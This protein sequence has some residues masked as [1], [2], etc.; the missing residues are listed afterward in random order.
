VTDAENQM[1]EINEL[2]GTTKTEQIE[3][4]KKEGSEEKL[5]CRLCGKFRP[6]GEFQEIVLAR[7]QNFAVKY[8]GCKG[9]TLVIGNAKV[10]IQEAAKRFAE[11]MAKAQAVGSGIG[12]PKGILGKS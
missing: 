5:F 12:V 10:L 8:H 9:C 4:E 2:G 3:R 11:E 7:L 6:A 1:K